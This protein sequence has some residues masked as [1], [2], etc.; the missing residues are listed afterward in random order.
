MRPTPPSPPGW[1]CSEPGSGTV[2]H[3]GT[4]AIRPVPS[5]AMV[6]PAVLVQL[7]DSHIGA[8]WSEGDP[9]AGSQGRDRRDRASG[10]RSR[11]DPGL[12]RSR[13]KWRGGRIRA[14]AGVVAGHRCADPRSARKPRRPSGLA[15]VLRSARGSGGTDPA[16][17]GRRRTT[18]CDGGQHS[19]GRGSWRAGLLSGSSGS[20][21]S[22]RL[23]RIDPPC[24]RCTI[25]RS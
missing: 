9:V 23:R 2:R 7:T 18:P 4:A 14:R 11:R 19:A 5:R 12:R 21:E 3:D 10:C 25:R 20:T 15:Q 16:H 24:S 1:R 13:R 22:W 6:K 8:V 17:R